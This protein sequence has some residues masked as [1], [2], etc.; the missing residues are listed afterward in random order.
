MSAP[1]RPRPTPPQGSG[2]PSDELEPTSGFAVREDP[3]LPA[4]MLE[5]LYARPSRKRTALVVLPV[6]AGLG[7][8]AFVGANLLWPGDPDPVATPTA[9]S[10]DSSADARS[11]SDETL[12]CWDGKP[13][14]RT[15]D[16]ALP[17]GRAGLSHVF[18]SFDPDRMECRDEL[19]A[20]PQYQR[21]AMW[22]CEQELTGPV[23]LTY[24]QV[25]SIKSARRYFDKLHGAS[26]VDA[27]DGDQRRRERW[28][29][30]RLTG[31][32]GAREFAGSILLS[33]APYAVTVTAQ[34]RAD[35]GRA[36]DT[37]VQV[38]PVD[39]LRLADPE[40]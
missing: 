17:T 14:A 18:P 20:N 38:R 16:C 25:S 9:T 13:A 34:N 37:L 21:P 40:A 30:A 2:V 22:T 1:R 32:E 27:E 12:T 11:G 33:G 36:L 10:E 19:V 39:R 26:S 4:G 24:S 35:V 28:A 6:L 7:V 5:A 31:S 15:K 29:T 23:A 3:G 8:A